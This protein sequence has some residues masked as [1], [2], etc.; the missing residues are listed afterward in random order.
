[1]I[2][3]AICGNMTWNGHPKFW[4]PLHRWDHL[5]GK[6]ARDSFLKGRLELLAKKLL[7]PQRWTSWELRH[8]KGH[9]TGLEKRNWILLYSLQLRH[10]Q[11]RFPTACVVSWV[12]DVQTQ[13]HFALGICITLTRDDIVCLFGPK[14]SILSFIPKLEYTSRK[15]N[16]HDC[17]KWYAFMLFAFLWDDCR[18]RYASIS[19]VL[20]LPLWGRLLC[21][22][23]RQSLNVFASVRGMLWGCFRAGSERGSSILLFLS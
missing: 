3:R 16:V 15:S 10:P 8:F 7:Y 2:C 18:K 12:L 4:N 5:H 21:F 9:Q 1:M 13:L 22:L 17:E 23:A 11:S 14:V 20:D 6:I 19:C